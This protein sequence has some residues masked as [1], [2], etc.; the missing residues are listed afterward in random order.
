MRGAYFEVLR[1][2]IPGKPPIRALCVAGLTR[3]FLL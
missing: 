3:E 1:L 2:L